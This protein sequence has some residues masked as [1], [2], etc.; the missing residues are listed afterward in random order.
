MHKKIGNIL[1]FKIYI[2]HICINI[3]LYI[4][5]TNIMI[6]ITSLPD[7]VIYSDQFSFSAT[8]TLSLPP[9][10]H[11]D[12]WVSTHHFSNLFARDVRLYSTV[13]L[14]PRD[15]MCSQELRKYYKIIRTCHQNYCQFATRN[16]FVTRKRGGH[17]NYCHQEDL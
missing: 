17:S 4:M 14:F 3:L 7:I 6:H 1:S 13:Q 5:S 12:V 16:L 10:G 2:K 9:Q 11:S 15:V 8:Y